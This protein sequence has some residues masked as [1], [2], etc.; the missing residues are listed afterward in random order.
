[1]NRGLIDKSLR[2]TW[3]T[4]LVFGL[5]LAAVETILSYVIPTFRGELSGALLQLKFMQNF[6]E[7]LLGTEIGEGLGPEVFDALPWVHPVALTIIWAQEISF[8]TRIP[9][10]EIDRGTVD[11]LLGM[12]VSRWQVYLCDSIVCMASGAGLLCLA[13]LGYLTGTL[14]SRDGALP[15][16]GRL[17]VVLVN[18]YCLYLAVAGVAYLLSAFGNR[19]G[20]VVGG[21]ISVLLASFLLNFLAR[22][23][24]PAE[25][26]SFLSF[27]TYYRPL[28]SFK[29]AG[30]PLADMAILCTV[31]V[32]SWLVGA[33]VFRHRDVCTV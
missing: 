12:P 29:D 17:M 8:C 23:W 22:F 1:M 14:F 32:S 18:L 28:Y 27:L 10:G 24:E 2:E 16:T 6:V 31:A 5:A 15:D 26:L 33:L 3:L 25:D 30:W 20:R 13:L 7:A 19:R 21:I 9:A 11:V 4:T